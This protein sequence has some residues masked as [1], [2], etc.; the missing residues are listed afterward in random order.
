LAGDLGDHVRGAFERRAADQL[1][2][3]IHS[4]VAELLDLPFDLG[5]Q[6]VLVDVH[7]LSAGARAEQEL[8]AVGDDD[9][10]PEGAR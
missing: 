5:L 3:R 1:P 4:R 8:L 2:L 6:V 9:L 7:R 10:R